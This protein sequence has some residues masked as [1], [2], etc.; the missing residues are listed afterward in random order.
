MFCYK[1]LGAFKTVRRKFDEYRKC[2]ESFEHLG[3]GAFVYVAKHDNDNVVKIG[4]SKDVVRRKKQLG[5][6]SA[7]LGV[8]TLV[9]IPTHNDVLHEHVAHAVLRRYHVRCEAGDELFNVKIEFAVGVLKMIGAA[10]YVAE[11]VRSSVPMG[12][13]QE[14]MA[15]AIGEAI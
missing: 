11:S 6:T 10:L 13:L 2:D 7:S 12:V 8:T 3:R 14:E 15:R 5:A 9:P 4:R 1:V